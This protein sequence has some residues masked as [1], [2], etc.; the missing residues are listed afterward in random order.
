MKTPLFLLLLFPLLIFA[1]HPSKFEEPEVNFRVQK[2]YDE[3][4]NLIRYDSSR[5]EKGNS[6]DIFYS[7]HFQ[8]DSIHPW[9]SWTSD[10][11][12]IQ[13]FHFNLDKLPPLDSMMLPFRNRFIDMDSLVNK[14]LEKGFLLFEQNDPLKEI[15]ELLNKHFEKM[16]RLFE[17]HQEDSNSKKNK[18]L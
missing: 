16:E 15:D 4:G 9:K 5:V 17:S 1:Q 14:H 12:R 2:D 7:Y 11:T 18:S 3:H 8:K 6:K 10:S 13:N